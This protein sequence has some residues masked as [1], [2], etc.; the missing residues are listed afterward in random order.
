MSQGGTGE[1][2]EVGVAE[3]GSGA[4]R[5]QQR[6]QRIKAIPHTRLAS[7]GMPVAKRNVHLHGWG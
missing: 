7:S 4:V 6:R 1:R 5:P 3:V 2:D